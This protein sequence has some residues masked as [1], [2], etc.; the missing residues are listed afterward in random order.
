MRLV[1]VVK[2]RSLAMIELDS[3]GFGGHIR[4]ADCVTP[5]VGRY[6]FLRYPNEPK[7]FDIDKG[8]R[9]EQGKSG[10]LLI[11]ALVVYEQAILIDTL[12][13]TDDSKRLVGE[14]L[15]WGNSELG[16]TFSPENIRRW[17][18]I[19]HLIFETDIPLLPRL[20]PP[21]Q[22]LAEKTSVITNQIFDGLPYELS[23]VYVGHDPMVRKNAIASFMIQHRVNT[24]FEENHYFSEAPLPTHLHIQFLEELE[25]DILAMQL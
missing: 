13:S 20:S 1:A 15:E 10:N 22:R 23:Q 2:A 25:Q 8:I 3:L 14:M 6:D 21:L 7:D 5:I 9:F 4:L 24:R 18:H 11:D 16:L 17:G 19:S 12:S